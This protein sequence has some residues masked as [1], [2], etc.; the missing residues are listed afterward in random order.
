MS[1][2]IVA[3]SACAR[4]AIASVSLLARLCKAHVATI[5]IALVVHPVFRH[6]ACCAD[7]QQVLTAC[8]DMQVHLYEASGNLIEAFSGHESWVLDVVAHPDGTHFLSSSSDASVKL[9][10]IPQRT[11]VTTARE[12]TDQVW[13]LALNPDGTEAASCGDDGKVVT[14]GLQ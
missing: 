3:A 6:P 13:A 11:C 4:H 8:D 2:N 9:W 5:Y 10:D 1:C 12:H 14:Y 7:S